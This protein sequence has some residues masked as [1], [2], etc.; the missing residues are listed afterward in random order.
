VGLAS[1]SSWRSA[2]N[3]AGIRFDCKQHRHNSP[4]AFRW[5]IDL[6]DG[7]KR[8][9]CR[10]ICAH[11]IRCWPWLPYT[12]TQVG[13]YISKLCEPGPGIYRLIGLDDANMPAV[14]NRLL[15]QD[16]TGTLYIGCEGKNFAVRSRLT[17]L[18]RSLRDYRYNDEHR[19]GY[20]LRSHPILSQ[21][22]PKSRLAI[23]WH[24]TNECK[25]AEDC[26]LDAYFTSFG[27]LPPLNWRK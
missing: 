12:L 19:A 8:P 21:R 10:I 26:L 25:L 1:R 20:R 14:L 11:T 22:F 18:V 23:T 3:A 9:L 7:P 2:A 27:D 13:S 4:V 24:Y 15:G 16:H 17:K 6:A 5:L